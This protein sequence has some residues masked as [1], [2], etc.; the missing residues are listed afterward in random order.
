MTD[1]QAELDRLRTALA[2]S[3]DVIY[4]WDLTDDTMHWHGSV[5]DIFGP[6]VCAGLGT[7]E[8]YNRSVNPQDLPQ[9]LKALSDHFAT[10]GKFD[11]EYRV[12]F[13]HGQ[14]CWVHERGAAEF[15]KDGEPL[16]MVAVVRGIDERK[17]NEARLEYL[18]NHDELTGLFSKTRLRG[19]LDHALAYSTRY[20]SP[21]AY[22][23]IGIDKLTL[24]NDTFGY[25]TADAIIV[26]VAQRLEKCLRASDV[27]GRVG[28]D[29]FGVVLSHGSEA[30]AT[31]TA[32]KILC[33]VR[34]TPAETPSG[35]LH[36]TVSI[37]V[38]TFPGVSDSV[39]DIMTKAETALQEAKRHGRNCFV[40]YYMSDSQRDQRRRNMRIAEKVRTALK[41]NRLVFAYQPIVEAKGRKV[42]YYECLLRMIGEDGVIVAA[43]EFVHVVEQL[44]LIRLIDRHVL[45]MAVDQLVRYPEVKLALN[46]SGLT[47]ADR[48]WL[49]A[50]GALLKDKPEVAGRLL[51]EITETAAM[52]DIEDSALFVSGVRH[53][54]CHVALDD[55]GAGYTSFR[56]LKSLMV[57]VVKIDGSFVRNVADNLDNQLFVRTLVRLAEG[58][59]L[60]TVAECVETAADADLLSR[61]GVKYLQGYEFGRPTLERP[62]LAP[63][64]GH[65]GAGTGVGT[66]IAPACDRK[67]IAGTGA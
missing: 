41:R 9:R 35:P 53:L 50:I 42:A 16:R 44:G 3:G 58:F 8:G 17:R 15:S 2:A 59:G 31:A 20:N 55:F 13:G 1:G 14:F 28:G 51:I 10:A 18:A 47:V 33:A 60:E 37:G 62:W 49:R 63:G 43:A 23:V 7:G 66:G 25:E 40:S 34:M 48:S 5:A 56:H 38:I 45:E 67:V 30:V 4:D 21:G 27:I 52:Q 6:E 39:Y 11:C 46:V 26:Q 65:A 57:N 32:D 29:R 19:G 36:V 54:G 61:Q 24:I 12:R 22:L 64:E